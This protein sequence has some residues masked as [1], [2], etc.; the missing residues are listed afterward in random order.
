MIA[1]VPPQLRAAH[2]KTRAVI[3]R[4][5][6]PSESPG[7]LPL[8]QASC[9][10][11]VTAGKRSRSTPIDSLALQSTHPYALIPFLLLWATAFVL[12]IRQ[13][14]YLPSS[15]DIIGCS[16]SPWDDWPPDGCEINGVDC[17]DD[18]VGLEGLRFRCMG[19]CKDTT[20]GNVRWVGDEKVNGVPL[21]IG[22]GDDNHTYRADSW[23]CAAA[24][25]ASLISP[26]LG[27]CVSVHP[28]AYPSGFSNFLSSASHGIVST[29]FAAPFPGAFTLS[30]LSS[31]G[32]WD[33]HYI[34][35]GFNAL[36]LLLTTIFLRPS[37][38]LLFSI[39]LVLGYFHIVLLSDAPSYP[40]NWETILGGLIPVLMT[41]YWA[42]KMAFKRTMRGFVDLP[43][44]MGLWQGAGYWIGI[45]SSTI[46]ARLPISRLGYDALDPS[47]VIALTFIVV[48]V[49]IV[50]LI[51]AWDMRKMGL[52]RYYLARYVVLIPILIVLAVIPDYTLRLHHYI[53]ALIAIPVLSLPNRVSL[54]LQAFMLGLWLDGVGRWGWA[55]IIEQTSS[56]LGDA[57]SGNWT[58][59]FWTN[60][61]TNAVL[62]WSPIT[63]EQKAANVTGYSVLVNDMQR[64]ADYP[65]STLDLSELGI[66]TGMDTFFRIA[67]VANGSSLDFSDPV[68]LW[69]DGSWTD[70]TDI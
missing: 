29:G 46:F 14:Y 18:L 61:T 25:H 66:V 20:L 16:A 56:L 48:V 57:N 2:R 13:Q 43:V 26:T 60:I 3:R 10:A 21:L 69:R 19:G 38:S 5:L 68:T 7:E 9:S 50:V 34:L 45:E 47:G 53:L 27:G 49:V 65:N 32:C 54:F 24:I 58:P 64:Y 35:T 12:L 63:E 44:E 51:Q 17:K 6:G 36:C 30:P 31:F 33:L 11:S 15:P 28:L 39:L 70:F 59:D 52:L 37:P 4:I 23:L 67:Y 55:S 42:W 40:P 62:A 22:G 8:P 41:G 1:V